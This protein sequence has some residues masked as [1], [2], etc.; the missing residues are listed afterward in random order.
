MKK[1]IALALALGLSFS[2]LTGCGGKKEEA[3]QPADTTQ[4]KTEQP[5]ETTKNEG[6]NAGEAVLADGTYKAEGEYDERGWKPVVTLEVKDGKIVAADYD[7]VTEDGA[8]KQADEEY[9]NNM[10]AKVNIGPADFF[11]QLEA[12]LVEKQDVDAVDTI[13]GATSGSN[14]FK[15]IVK[16]ALAAGPVA[17]DTTA[18]GLKDGTYTAEGEYDERGW[19][20]TISIEVKDGKIVAVDYDE[21]TEDGASKEADEAYNNNMKAKVNIGPADYFPQL[22]AALVEKQDADAVDTIT[23]ATH[24]SENFRALAKKALEAAK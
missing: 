2:A 22:E 12:A 4:T 9:N 8:S 23:G 18:G 6:N 3:S 24:G 5:A 21:V 14:H 10:R 13:T 20:P 17:A 19:K 1:V 7:E 16:K 15:E 11:P